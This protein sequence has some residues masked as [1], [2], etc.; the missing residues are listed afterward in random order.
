MKQSFSCSLN[1]STFVKDMR[2]ITTSENSYVV[3]S[4]TGALYHGEPGFPLKLV[5]ENVDAGML[6][7]SVFYSPLEYVHAALS[8]C[9]MCDVF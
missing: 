4:N 7:S 3:L 9:S 1:N 8:I 5:M 6:H 2:W